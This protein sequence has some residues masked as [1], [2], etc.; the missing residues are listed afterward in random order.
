MKQKFMITLPK[1]LIIASG[2]SHFPK[3]EIQ[4]H[5]RHH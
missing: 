2:V 4:Q 3:R 1:P 5:M